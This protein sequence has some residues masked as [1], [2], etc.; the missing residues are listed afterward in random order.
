MHLH[1]ILHGVNSMYRLI[2]DGNWM[3]IVTMTIEDDASELRT[4]S[5]YLN[6]NLTRQHSLGKEPNVGYIIEHCRAHEP[7]RKSSKLA[8]SK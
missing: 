8:F 6:W 3:G 2:V 7:Q 4:T 1:S 5:M